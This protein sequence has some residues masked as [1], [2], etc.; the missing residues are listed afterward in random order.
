MMSSVKRITFFF[1]LALITFLILFLVLGDQLAAIFYGSSYAGNGRSIS[2]LGLSMFFS[3]IALGPTYGMWAM[4]RP[5]LNFKI[6]LVLLAI[7]FLCGVWLVRSLGVF[8][9]SIALFLTNL[10][11]FLSR[12]IVFENLISNNTPS[13][14]Q[15]SCN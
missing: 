8:G 10:I 12:Y 9:A 6:N 2:V 1:A 5:D 15:T 11:S 3:G 14:T 7:S 13:G 4:E